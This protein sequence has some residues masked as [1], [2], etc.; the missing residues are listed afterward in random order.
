MTAPKPETAEVTEA[1][2][3]A[4]QNAL[5][6]IETLATEMAGGGYFQNDVEVLKKNREVL[7]KFIQIGNTI[8]QV[9]DELLAAEKAAGNPNVTDYNPFRKPHEKKENPLSKLF[10]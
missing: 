1:P 10:S 2:K 4:G 3:S 6:M 7:S 9:H 5:E 8:R